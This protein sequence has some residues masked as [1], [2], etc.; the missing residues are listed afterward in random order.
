MYT[1]DIFLFHDEVK[2]DLKFY[3]ISSVRMK[4]MISLNDGPKKTKQLRKLTGIQPS[5]IIH[6]INEL[7]KQK[8]VLKEEDTYYLSEIGRILVPKYIDMIKSM[9]ILKNSQNLW[10]KHEI[11]AIPHHL[12]MEIGDLSNSQLIESDNTDIFK[13]HGNFVNMVSQ[14]ENI[15]GVSTV[16]HP[17][18]VGVFR[19]IIDKNSEIKVELILTDEV[20]K[21]TIMSIHKTN[22]KDLI[23]WVSKKN[24]ILW[25]LN[26]DAKVGFTV[27]DNFLSLGLYKKNGTY[28]S[29][30]DL[31]SEHPDAIAWGNKLFDYYQKKADKIELK[32]L[33]KLISILI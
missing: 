24:L 26:E 7:V 18:F 29:L 20:L 27:T 3:G 31:I 8:I 17:D 28:D 32:R 10:L 6:G 11:D 2:D 25:R 12:L 14:S 9:V 13:T 15:R 33:D 19:K 4:I 1:D 5:T 22:L 21:K 23:R 30:R 16:F